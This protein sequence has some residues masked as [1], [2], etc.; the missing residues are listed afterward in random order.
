M[1][2]LDLVKFTKLDRITGTRGI[3]RTDGCMFTEMDESLKNEI[4][5]LESITGD[6][7]YAIEHGCSQVI[8]F[9]SNLEKN[10][11]N[12]LKIVYDDMANNNVMIKELDLKDFKIYSKIYYNKYYDRERLIILV[13]MNVKKVDLPFLNK[14]AL[15]NESRIYITLD[16]YNNVYKFPLLRYPTPIK[17]FFKWLKKKKKISKKVKIMFDRNESFGSCSGWIPK[18]NIKTDGEIQDYIKILEEEGK[19]ENSTFKYTKTIQRWK[20]EINEVTITQDD[21]NLYISEAN[22]RY[23]I[24]R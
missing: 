6:T 20:N 18:K 2:I 21:I 24:Y 8:N 16:E 17:D 4:K 13:F 1:D 5:Q 23:K 10:A 15:S 3:V 12:E 19:K 22:N 7:L 14:T 9:I 11:T